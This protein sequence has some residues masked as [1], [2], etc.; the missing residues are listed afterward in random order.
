MTE[1]NV[2]LRLLNEYLPAYNSD[3]VLKTSRGH[4]RERL[5]TL[6]SDSENFRLKTAESRQAEGKTVH[7]E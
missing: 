3:S 1:I 4:I 6:F 7:Y 5:V 2:V